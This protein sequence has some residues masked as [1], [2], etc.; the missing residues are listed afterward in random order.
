MRMR[1]TRKHGDDP[2][3]IAVLHGG[4]GA[5]GD[6]RPLAKGLSDENGVLEPLFD[7]KSIQGQLKWLEGELVRHGSLP[8][9]LIGHSWGAWLA[10]IFVAEYPDYV[11]KLILVGSGP[12]EVKYVI[13]MKKTLIRR[14]DEGQRK[15]YY[16]LRE[17]ME[18]GG[19]RWLDEYGELITSVSSYDMIESGEE[20]VEVLAEVNESVWREAV[21]TRRSG[22][23]LDMGEDI[24][25]P[26]VAIHGEYD[27]HP[28]EGLKEPLERVL[29]DFKFILLEKC[30]HYPWR[31]KW[32]REEFFEVLVDEL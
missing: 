19:D 9:N 25:M 24:E 6:A 28:Y 4:P 23:L 3:D 15:R 26:V 10:W 29:D 2:F 12:F 14:M 31:E 32:A 13:E 8:V 22:E 17:L 7:Q 30:G 27:H 18:D 11:E 5:L 21:E 16:E 1:K 20:E